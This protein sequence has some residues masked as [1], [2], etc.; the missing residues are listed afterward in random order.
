MSGMAR[1]L[2]Y[3]FRRDL[4]LNDNPVI[5]EIARLNSQSQKP[6]THLL[7]VFVFSAEQV[8]T[9]GFV[10]EGQKSPYPEARSKVGGFHRCGSLRAKFLAESVWDLKKD[11]ES[12]GSGLQIRV[13]SVKD[14][15]RSILDGYRD[16]DDVQ[17]HGLWMTSEEAWEEHEEEKEVRD[18]MHANKK[19]FKLWDDEKYFVHEYAPLH[20]SRDLTKR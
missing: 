17:I 15:V 18:L 1:V 2:I 6:F 3:L 20:I 8:E 7:P 13:G 10:T 9:S 19:E 12:I 11:L 4:R 16:Q 14:A 5:T